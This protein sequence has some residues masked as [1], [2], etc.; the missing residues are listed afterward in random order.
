MIKRF[1]FLLAITCF[2]TGISGFAQ[3][4]PDQIRFQKYILAG[5]TKS[6]LR[7]MRNEI[8][9]RYGYRFRSNDLKEW[10]EQ[11]RW[12]HPSRNNVDSLLTEIDKENI[13]LIQYYETNAIADTSGFLLVSEDMSWFRSFINPN[14]GRKYFN[15]HFLQ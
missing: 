10:F 1:A 9:A 7:L 4:K 2:V 6:E 3:S 8:F 5:K 12:Y 14:N 13:R 15:K 11:K